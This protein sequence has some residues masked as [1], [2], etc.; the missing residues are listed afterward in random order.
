MKILILLST[1]LFLASCDNPT[2]TRLQPVTADVAFTD[3]VVDSSV[4][5]VAGSGTD[6]DDGKSTND[7]T[8][9]NGFEDCNLGYQYYGGPKIG[10]FGLCQS[11][12]FDSIF[13]V[14]LSQ[15]DLVTGVC[16][17]PVHIISGGNSYKIGIAECV[18][19]ESG[20]EYQFILTKQSSEPINGVM[21]IKAG[22]PT[23]EYFNCMSARSTFIAQNPGCQNSQQCMIQ[24][25]SYANY[26]CTQFVGT[27]STFYS[28]V[29]L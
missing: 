6:T 21:V 14:K 13:K 15:T 27:Y 28:Q 11:T 18:R 8:V 9:V 2:R 4:N 7:P 10:N 3:D 26:V 23:N 12:E 25:D 19:N 29:N 17:V 24:A 1:I 22:A 5:P 20:K 16:F